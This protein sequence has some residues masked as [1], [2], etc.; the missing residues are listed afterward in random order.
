[1]PTRQSSQDESRNEAVVDGLLA[2]LTA[3]YGDRLT[4]ENVTKVRGDIA[5]LVD[6][7]AVLRQVPLVNADEPDLAFAPR[8]EDG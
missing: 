6:A 1:M 5:E 3:R 2:A 4:D 7:V 8:R